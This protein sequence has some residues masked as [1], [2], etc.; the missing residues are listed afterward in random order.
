MEPLNTYL[1]EFRGRHGI[2]FNSAGITPVPRRTAERVRHAV[3]RMEEG[4]S[5]HDSNFLAESRRARES[6]TDFLGAL[7]GQVALTPNC[8]TA[9]SVAALGFPLRSTDRVLTLDQE[10][11][12]NFY[13]WKVACE[14][15][16]ATLEVLGS[17]MG[18][19]VDQDR[20]L[21]AI[22]PGVTIVALSWVQFQTGSLIDLEKIGKRCHEVGAFFVVDAIQGLGQLPFRFQD[23][24]VDFVAG[25]S[26]KWLCSVNGQGFFA[27]KPE[28][29]DRL[30]PIAVGGGTF[31]RFGTYADPEARMELSARRFEPGGFGFLPLLALESSL[32][33]ISMLGLAE[34]RSRI[35]GLSRALRQGL[36][37]LGVEMV[38]PFDQSGGI[39][40]FRLSDGE[41]K[42]FLDAAGR[43]RIALAKRGEFIRLSPHA[44]CTEAEVDEVLHVLKG[45]RK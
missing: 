7:P 21:D 24:P 8:A 30:E 11:S 31:N 23:L 26:H 4:T 20:L 17:G 12:S 40:S 1:E 9:L 14:R 5:L 25:G 2:H 18:L 37:E 41:E 39:T 36:R 10:Y 33:V 43:A 16:G 35:E 19:G 29:M 6:L 42:A 13:P 27:V 38:T 44:F 34:I 45:V 32:E 15:S 3:S 22:R 28:F